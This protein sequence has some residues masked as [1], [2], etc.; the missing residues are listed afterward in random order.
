MRKLIIKIHRY[1][2]LSAGAL[3]CLIGVTGSLLVFDHAIDD[4][5]N[6]E[7]THAGDGAHVSSLSELV[8]AATQAYPQAPPTRVYLARKQGAAHTV[9]FPAPEGASGPVEVSVNP[10]TAEVVAVRTWGSYLSSWVYRLHYTLL[11]GNAGKN[12]VGALGIIL[13]F[14]CVSGVYLWWPKRGRWIQAFRV[15]RKRGMYRFHYDLH[16]SLGAITVVVLLVSAFSGVSLVFHAPVENAVKT[17]FDFQAWPNPRSRSESG[18]DFPLDQAA[19][20]AQQSFPSAQLKRVYFP[21]SADA[22]FL[23]AFNQPGEAWSTYAASRVW[24]DRYTGEVLHV[25]DPLKAAATNKIMTWQFPLH[26]GDALGLVGRLV[27]F[28][29]GWV[30]LLLFVSGFY[31]WYRRVRRLPEASMKPYLR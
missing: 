16:K 2:G 17:F 22:P 3:L 29:C 26:N 18:K 19:A 13:F 12:T 25:W 6:P 21:Q 31:T 24:M 7:L 28:V 5:I 11:A 20:I 8:R 30:P 9:R 1:L 23:F 14:F 27:L 10:M 15:S 4:A